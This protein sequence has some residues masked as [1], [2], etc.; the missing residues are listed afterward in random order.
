MTVFTCVVLSFIY[1]VSIY[2][3]ILHELATPNHIASRQI[4]DDNTTSQ[5]RT[6]LHY[7]DVIMGAIASQITNLMIVYSTVYSDADQR[8]HQSSASLACVGNSPGPV[9]SPHERQVTL[10]MF[11]DVIMDLYI[12]YLKLGYGW[13][14]TSRL[15]MGRYYSWD[16]QKRRKPWSE[17][18]NQFPHSA[19]VHN[20]M[21]DKFCVIRLL[22][23]TYVHNTFCTI[24]N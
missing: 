3:L 7:G 17:R 23:Q 20:H 16:N 24:W 2:Y 9:N 18:V 21:Y 11:D 8:K 12:V 19:L 4:S 5:M 10:K 13:V 15:F 22:Y 14:F 1:S 6:S